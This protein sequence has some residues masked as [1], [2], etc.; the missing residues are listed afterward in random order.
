MNTGEKQLMGLVQVEHEDTPMTAE[1]G[2]IIRKVMRLR[3]GKIL[4]RKCILL[5]IK[6]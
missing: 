1:P 5:K 6:Y 3:V 4:E 2:V